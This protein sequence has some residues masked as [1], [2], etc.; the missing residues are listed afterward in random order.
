MKES[1]KMIKKK[2]GREQKRRRRASN[3]DLSKDKK[4]TAIPFNYRVLLNFKV[5]L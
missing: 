5:S 1:D 4:I 2:I 3:T